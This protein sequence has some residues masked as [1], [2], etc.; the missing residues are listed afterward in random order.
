MTEEPVTMG[1]RMPKLSWVAIALA[2]LIAGF[3]IWLLSGRDLVAADVRARGLGIA[4]TWAELGLK[5]SPAPRLEAWRRLGQLATAVVSYQQATEWRPTAGYVPSDQMVQHHRRLPESDLASL[6]NLCDGLEPDGIVVRTSATWDTLLPEI[7]WIRG[8]TRLLSERIMLAPPELV[9]GESRRLLAVV[10]G[11]QANTLIQRL[12]SLSC[13]TIWQQAVAG[14][15]HEDGVDRTALANQA[16]AA[17]AWLAGYMANA[18]DDELRVWRE[19]AGAVHRGEAKACGEIEAALD[20]GGLRGFGIGRVVMRAG[21]GVLLEQFTDLSD[22][23]RT[24]PDYRSRQTAIAAINKRLGNGWSPGNAI[25]GL[26]LP[27]SSMISDAWLKCD[28]GL[29][30]LAAELRQASW[31]VD[32]S[33]PAGG[34]VRRVERSGRLIGYYLLG[35]NQVDDG[36]RIKGDFCQ[37]LYERLGPVLAADPPKDP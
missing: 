13:L 10:A 12:V 37:A 7:A 30:V 8:L 2:L 5:N 32:P 27:A 21:R 1:W 4:P 22:A 25:A 17:R 35:G 6:L 34:Q 23:W 16:D 26:A 28:V 11:Q 18:I 14:R 19:A 29:A 31:P 20:L 36:G 3:F 9:A 33:D 24:S 15:L